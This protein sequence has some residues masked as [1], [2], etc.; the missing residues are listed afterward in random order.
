[1]EL[2]ILVVDD[3]K[4]VIQDCRRTF[5]SQ[6][7]FVLDCAQSLQEAQKLMREH[8]YDLMFVDFEL[9]TTR[10]QVFE[11]EEVLD[12]AARR[13]RLADLYAWTD[14]PGLES[15]R[16]LIVES[17]LNPDDPIAKQL[18]GL[19]DKTRIDPAQKAL[20]IAR[21]LARAKLSNPVSLDL[22]K[23]AVVLD[24]LNSGRTIAAWLEP[25]EVATSARLEELQYLVTRLFG[26][27]T[28][29]GRHSIERVVEIDFFDELGA[30]GG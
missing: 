27:G 3:H 11:G 24:R 26:Q 10:P 25:S 4:D 19:I 2:R 5:E 15:T 9:D 22:D 20:A 23:L 6:T 21:D 17:L 1:V 14:Y 7:E 30:Q 8:V 18:C 28:D 16:S 12:Y 13:H 29:A